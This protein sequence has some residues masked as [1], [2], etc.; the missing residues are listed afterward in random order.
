M[1]EIVAE[2]N[3]PHDN[4][5]ISV[6][7]QGQVIGYIPA[8]ETYKYW[9]SVISAQNQGKVALAKAKVTEDTYGN[10]SISLYLKSDPKPVSGAKNEGCM[11]PWMW[12]VLAF[13]VIALIF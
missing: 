4:T 9:D 7:H 3:N 8:V 6:R 12:F 11:K 13:I 5:A 2:P 1:L 10:K